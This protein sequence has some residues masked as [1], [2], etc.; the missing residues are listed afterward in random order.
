V[1]EAPAGAFVDE[2]LQ[3]GGGGRGGVQDLER[4]EDV[5]EG[6]E[7]LFGIAPA[8]GEAYEC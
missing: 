4:G 7:V 1:G 5:G 8:F 3:L 2:V 6:G